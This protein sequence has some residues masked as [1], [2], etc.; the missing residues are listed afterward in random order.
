LWPTVRAG[1]EENEETGGGDRAWVEADQ[2]FDEDNKQQDNIRSILAG[3][4]HVY[5]PMKTFV[6]DCA[7]PSLL[8]DRSMKQ[9]QA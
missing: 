2:A 1:R 4:P 5:Q 8:A 7:T 6:G 3:V 9:T